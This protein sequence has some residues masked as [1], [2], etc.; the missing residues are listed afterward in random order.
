MKFRD[1]LANEFQ[2]QPI[3]HIYDIHSISSQILDDYYQP[4]IDLLFA[5]NNFLSDPKKY[6]QS[7][8]DFDNFDNFEKTI[9]IGIDVF[10]LG[11]FPNHSFIGLDNRLTYPS[12]FAFTTTTPLYPSLYTSQQYYHVENRIG[13]G[14]HEINH[15]TSNDE[16]NNTNNNTNNANDLENCIDI[17]LS[18]IPIE[19][20]SIYKKFIKQSNG[21][22]WLDLIDIDRLFLAKNQIETIKEQTEQTERMEKQEKQEKQEKHS[23]DTLIN[24]SSLINPSSHSNLYSIVSLL[25][26]QYSTTN[27]TLIQKHDLNK[28]KKFQQNSLVKNNPTENKFPLNQFNNNII[29]TQQS[30]ETI[31]L[32]SNH[33]FG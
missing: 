4:N 3:K 32:D 33:V 9:K 20:E 19:F 15:S 8:N 12:P 14:I 18:K 1:R 24:C 25:Y 28:M 5:K 23:T 13:N 10:Q 31:S 7:N 6:Q 26:Y 16:N 29:L 21:W 30:E 11:L 2:F 27:S 22:K 17:G